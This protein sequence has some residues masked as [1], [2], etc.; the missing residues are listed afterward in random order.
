MISDFWFHQHVKYELTR[1][2]WNNSK[3]TIFRF[4]P[5]ISGG[6]LTVTFKIEEH[7]LLKKSSRFQKKNTYYYV[8]TNTLVHSES[9]TNRIQNDRPV[10][11]TTKYTVHTRGVQT[12]N[13]QVVCSFHHYCLLLYTTTTIIA[14]PLLL[15][16]TTYIYSIG[17]CV[18]IYII[19]PRIRYGGRVS[20][21]TDSHVRNRQLCA[22]TTA[23]RCT[24]IITHVQQVNQC[25]PTACT[26]L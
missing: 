6:L 2:N 13:S 3:I 19:R 11:I 25:V 26:V 16:N 21:H 15:L 10:Y 8:E 24:I 20:T 14:L 4:F 1:K 5:H 17:N 22:N 7:L 9:K 12:S 18:L 23:Q